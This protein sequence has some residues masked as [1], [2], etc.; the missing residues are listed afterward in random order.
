M[1]NKGDLLGADNQ[2]AEVSYSKLLNNPSGLNS[3]PSG[4]IFD[5]K[6]YKI[7][8]M[9]RKSGSKGART[10]KKKQNVPARNAPPTQVLILKSEF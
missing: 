2:L 3:N 10:R 8:T 7:S 6:S 9:F 1:L 5:A 4:R